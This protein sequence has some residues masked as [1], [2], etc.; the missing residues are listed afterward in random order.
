MKNK[1]LVIILVFIFGLRMDLRISFEQGRS[2]IFALFVSFRIENIWDTI[3]V[4]LERDLNLELVALGL[5]P[6]YIILTAV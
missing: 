2:K 3:L 5:N 6:S 4:Y 1:N